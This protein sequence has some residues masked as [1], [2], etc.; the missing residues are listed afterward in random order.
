MIHRASKQE[1]NQLGVKDWRQLNALIDIIIALGLYKV[2]PLGLGPPEYVK[3]KSILLAH[4]A[5][6]AQYC[7]H[8]RKP[9][10]EKITATF[11]S[12]IDQGGEIGETLQRKHFI[13]VLSGIID[14]AFNPEY[15]QQERIVWKSQYDDIITSK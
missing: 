10:E 12:I 7:Q 3:Q 1:N 13:D 4:E 9:L 11:K 6:K 15:P 14:L 5:Q 2:Q 8:E